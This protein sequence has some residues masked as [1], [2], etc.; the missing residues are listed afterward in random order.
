[1]QHA[2]RRESLGGAYAHAHAAS[3][4]SLAERMRGS[5]TDMATGVRAV[6]RG[7][8]FAQEE[9]GVAI[10]RIQTNLSERR[11]ERRRSMLGEEGEG[12]G[13]RE[14]RGKERERRKPSTLSRLR[15]LSLGRSKKRR[16]QSMMDRSET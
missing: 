11:S 5:R 12:L 8:D 1:M 9:G 14:G 6:H 13:E 2:G 10:Q 4:P 16:E 15:V 7:F 3:V